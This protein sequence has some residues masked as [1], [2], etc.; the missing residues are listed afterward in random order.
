MNTINKQQGIG[1]VAIIFIIAIIAIG[2]YAIYQANV[3]EDMEI[4][5]DQTV[6]EIQAQGDEMLD[7]VAVIEAD[8]IETFAKVKTNLGLKTD[9]GLKLAAALLADLQ[10]RIDAYAASLTPNA[11]AQV[12]AFKKRVGSAHAKVASATV[13][14]IADV[15]AD[16]DAINAD[17]ESSFDDIEATVGADIDAMI[18]AAS[19]DD[20]AEEEMHDGQST[21]IAK[22]IVR[23]REKG[24][25]D[26]EIVQTLTRK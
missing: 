11:Q 24:K 15:A 16:V 2:G 20:D 8:V 7:T 17:I 23:L 21:K 22:E 4:S 13:D 14:T 10:V 19:D 12:N 18:E 25:S 5:D 1:I 6:E 9:E 3:S 26:P